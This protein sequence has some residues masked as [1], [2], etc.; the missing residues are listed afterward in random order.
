MKRLSR[1]TGPGRQSKQS[2]RGG[3]RGGRRVK[4]LSH[5]QL[6]CQVLENRRV[7]AASMGIQCNP[8]GLPSSDPGFDLVAEA[9]TTAEGEDQTFLVTTLDDELDS[10]P[11]ANLA[12]LS[13]R[14][15]LSLANQTS[16]AD[17]IAFADGLSGI[18]SLSASLG[19]LVIEDPVQVLGPGADQ[20]TVTALDTSRVLQLSASAGDVRIQGLTITGGRTFTDL[21]G[22][23]GI[24][25]LSTGTLTLDGV[26]VTGNSTFGQG[27][28]G[29]GVLS[30]FSVSNPSNPGSLTIIDSV[31]SDNQTNGLFSGGGGI[32]SGG[33][34]LTISNSTISGNETVSESAIGGGIYTSNSDVTITDTTISGNTTR[35]VNS[36]GGGIAS[37][38]GPLTIQSS[39]ISGNST[40]A[41]NAPGGGVSARRADLNFINSTISGNT[42]TSENGGGIYAAIGEVNLRHSTITGN[43]AGGQGGG[44]AVPATNSQ[45]VMSIAHTIIAGNTN[46]NGASPDLRAVDAIAA[47]D[48][49][50]FSLIGD[51]GG[52]VLSE[53]QTADPSNG[54]LVGDASGGGVIDPL[55]D[56]LADNGGP[57]LTHALLENS[58]AVNAGDPGFV[59]GDITTDQRGTGFA[60]VADGRI[61]LGSLERSDAAPPATLD[62]GDAGT[63]YPVLLTDDGASHVVPSEA[64]RLTLGSQVDAESDGQVSSDANGDGPD[65]D[66]VVS[67]TDIVASA[68]STT[69]AAFAVTASQPGRLDAW[70]DF[71]QDGD[72][73]DAGEQIFVSVDVTAGTNRLPFT[74]PAGATPGNTFARFR[75]SSAGGLSPTGEA[76]DGEVEDY[77]VTLVDGNAA[78][79]VSV[80]FSGNETT[81]STQSNQIIVRDGTTE[82]FVVPLSQIGS[83]NLQGSSADDRLTLDLTDGFQNPAGGVGFSGGQGNDTL[84]IVGDRGVID[85]SVAGVTLV[86]IETLDLSSPDF[87][88][89]TLNAAEIAS[90]TSD[91]MTLSI[92]LGSTPTPQDDGSNFDSLTISDASDW[93]LSDPVVRGGRFL[94]T[95]QVVDGSPRI[96]VDT[97]A[98]WQNVLRASD[99]SNDGVVSALDALQIINELAR[100]DFH[101]PDTSVLVDPLTIDNFPQLYYDQNG[102]GRVT[103]LDALRVINELALQPNTPPPASSATSVAPTA[104]TSSS[105]AD[106]S[107]DPGPA[108]EFPQTTFQQTSFQQNSTPDPQ[109]DDQSAANDAALIQLF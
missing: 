96:E 108:T 73:L 14:E 81:L 99:V 13:L 50:T 56:A 64:P 31:I 109:D 3:K 37:Q 66:G 76:S 10:N 86:G 6:T 88:T 87:S 105:Q 52:T 92:I 57:T 1:F 91:A 5:R 69:T 71:N 61:D 77:L 2:G 16:G 28:A 94:V 98:V 15:A 53:S 67:I 33:G 102:D 7:L 48:S 107:R 80:N 65:D 25:S 106:D 78:P 89:V 9:S 97:P 55:L 79:P 54:N 83:M 8:S 42:S 62:F 32:F 49:V 46:T 11:A 74:V 95:A 44:V 18:I 103:A 40:V 30:G 35:G 68:A 51:N 47:S 59:A 21:S 45:V 41:G 23:A 24:R 43:Q 84:A 85:F 26:I 29:A 27:S 100:Q 101:D 72:W 39:T 60:R 93:L 58:P 63:G 12:D 20:I 75:I 17:L 70:I 22:G 36:R 4:R 38:T 90:E 34:V 82:L 19:Q 104:G